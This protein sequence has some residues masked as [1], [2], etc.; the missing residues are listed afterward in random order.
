M[1]LPKICN[2]PPRTKRGANRQYAAILRA[3]KAA[4]DGGGAFG[5]DWPTFRSNWP[6]GWQKCQDIKAVYYSLPA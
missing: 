6:E 4:F 3:Y 1:N 2:K 5:W